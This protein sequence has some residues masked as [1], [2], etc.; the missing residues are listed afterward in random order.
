[1]TPGIPD[2][3]E[4]EFP[5]T[6]PSYPTLSLQMMTMMLLLLEQGG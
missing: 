1:M 3:I 6:P 2:E 4:I 5:V